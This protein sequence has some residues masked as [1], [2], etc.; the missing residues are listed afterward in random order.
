M[1]SATLT[2]KGQAKIPR[3]IRDRLGLKAGD[4]I[5]FVAL[6]DGSVRLMAR[7]LPISALKGMLPWPGRALRTEEISAAIVDAVAGKRR[8]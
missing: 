1:P 7:N 2:G 8:K 6:P 5:D 4:R 3:D